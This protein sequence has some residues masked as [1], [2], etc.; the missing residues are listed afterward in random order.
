ML[1]LIIP[2]SDTGG[3]GD[4]GGFVLPSDNVSSAHRSDRL[5]RLLQE[6]DEGFNLDPGF[7]I[8]ADGNIIEYG[9]PAQAVAPAELLQ[10]GSGSAVGGNVQPGTLEGLQ[11]RNSEV[12][13]KSWS[14]ANSKLS[15]RTA[16]SYGLG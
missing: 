7:N 5:A 2:T 12:C 3:A 13:L 16:R 4:L 6:E 1:G 9:T 11:T 8:D 10:L 14:T 15:L